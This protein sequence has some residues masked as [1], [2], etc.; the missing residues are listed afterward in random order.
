MPDGIT[1]FLRQ[2][3]SGAQVA[4][5]HCPILRMSK[6]SLSVPSC[7]LFSMSSLCAIGVQFNRRFCP[8]STAQGVQRR[9]HI[10][11]FI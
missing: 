4:P 6:S 1:L 11:A 7:I 10:H 8:M 9:R 2:I 5:Q 3:S